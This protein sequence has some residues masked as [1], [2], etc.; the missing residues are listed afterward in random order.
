MT[1]TMKWLSVAM[2]AVALA[3]LAAVSFATEAKI[4]RV[5]GG[6]AHT[7]P[8]FIGM[9]SSTIEFTTTA[10]Q[11]ASGQGL[12][13]AICPTGGTAGKYSSAI[14]SDI[15]TGLSVHSSGVSATLFPMI[16]P[17]VYSA[18]DSANAA[19]G[20]VG[21]FVPPWPIRF[22]KGLVGVQSDAGHRTVFY[23]R[24]DAGTNPY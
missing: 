6:L 3:S 17:A 12:L 1:K 9:R 2:L 11:V 21:C 15:S 10:K 20:M 14:D 8:S 18:A 22:E 16:A 5:G 19:A 13:Y 24:S 7:N 23:Y 4:P